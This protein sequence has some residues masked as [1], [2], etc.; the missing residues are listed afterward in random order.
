MAKKKVAI[1]GGGIGA[2]TSA[3]QLTNTP[4]WKDELEVTVYQ[5]GWR[6]GGKCF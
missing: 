2:L 5:M 3:F 6:L 1:L 4:N